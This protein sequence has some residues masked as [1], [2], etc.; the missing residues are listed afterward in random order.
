MSFYRDDIAIRILRNVIVLIFLL[1]MIFPVRVKITAWGSL[2]FSKTRDPQS[3]PRPSAKSKFFFYFY[4]TSILS[5]QRKH[6][7]LDAIVVADSIEPTILAN[8]A[9][10]LLSFSPI[11]CCDS[12]FA[13][14]AAA[15]ETPRCQPAFWADGYILVWP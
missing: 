4:R 9:V 10:A 1:H 11:L 2:W 7:R 6:T 15:S 8:L 3:V 13:V 12:V 14:T 5:W